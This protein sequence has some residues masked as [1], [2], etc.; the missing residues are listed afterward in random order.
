MY[1]AG[2]QIRQAPVS[3]VPRYC[4]EEEKNKGRRGGDQCGTI[5]NHLGVASTRD[6]RQLQRF[7]LANCKVAPAFGCVHS[8]LFVSRR[9]QKKKKGKGNRPTVL[10][11][12]KDVK[13]GSCCCWVVTTMTPFKQTLLRM[14]TR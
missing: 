4:A 11:L 5:E 6:V 1:R 3:Q 9:N 2:P 10:Q 8:R 12:Q 14:G 7:L 13:A